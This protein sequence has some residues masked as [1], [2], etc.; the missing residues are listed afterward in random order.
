MA[1]IF[2]LK[3]KD[4]IMLIAEA[5][6]PLH[7]SGWQMAGFCCAGFL[8]VMF[9]LAFQAILTALIGR[10]FTSTEKLKK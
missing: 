8:L 1:E 10:I 6:I 5:L 3:K 2:Y 4:Y 9:V 7:P